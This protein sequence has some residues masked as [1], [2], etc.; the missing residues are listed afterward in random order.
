[1]ENNINDVQLF[2]IFKPCKDT[3]G[4]F[5]IPFITWLQDMDLEVWCFHRDQFIPI[6]S[7][8]VLV[9]IV[10]KQTVGTNVKKTCRLHVIGV[11]VTPPFPSADHKL[12]Q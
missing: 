9:W 3:T 2:N 6:L 1:M 8:K 7:A 12:T 4:P 11:I 5:I 10:T